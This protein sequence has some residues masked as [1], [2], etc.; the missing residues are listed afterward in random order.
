MLNKILAP[1]DFQNIPSVYSGG[2]DAPELYIVLIVLGI[3]IGLIPFFFIDT[4]TK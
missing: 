2:N 4:E 3:I 1:I